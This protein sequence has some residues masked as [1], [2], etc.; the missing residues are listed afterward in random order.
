M[1]KIIN[2]L[3]VC[4]LVITQSGNAY[5]QVNGVARLQ[6]Q[7]DK[8]KGNNTELKE[9]SEELTILAASS[10]MYDI[11]SDNSMNVEEAIPGMGEYR[12]SAAFNFTNGNFE[13]TLGDS[14]LGML[15]HELKHA[16]QF[17]TGAFSS[18]NY[19][20]GSPF[21]DKSDELEAYSRGSLFGAPRVRSLPPLYDN[22]QN[23]PIDA[24]N[25]PNIMYLLGNPDVLQKI[26]NK[27]GTKMAF[28]IKGVT[29]RTSK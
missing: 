6:R 3:F 15:A 16:Y 17:E 1:S 14:S 7:I 13:I 20:N 29:Y 28:R 21:Y 11:R 8:L 22:L 25:H 4:I 26:V 12:S 19:S 5:G 9:V 24:T 27:S 18:S 23:G 10:Q 2:T